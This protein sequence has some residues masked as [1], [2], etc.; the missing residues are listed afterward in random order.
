MLLWG[1]Q[2]WFDV[3]SWGEWDKEVESL[4]E[5]MSRMTKEIMNSGFFDQPP[6]EVKLVF[7]EFPLVSYYT[8]AA[9]RHTEAAETGLRL[10]RE[11]AALCDRKRSL[12]STFV[13]WGQHSLFDS[14][15]AG[16]DGWAMTKMIGQKS[17]FLS[18]FETIVG[19]ESNNSTF[20]AICNRHRILWS[21]ESGFWSQKWTELLALNGRHVD[22]TWMMPAIKAEVKMNDSLSE[23]DEDD[24]EEDLDTV[25]G[26]DAGEET[27]SESSTLREDTVD[28]SSEEEVT[29]RPPTS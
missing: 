10:Y 6:E 1:L 19:M 13:D 25:K 21:G 29:D 7:R 22:M 8:I 2:N 28:T 27:G 14:K 4:D 26:A 16:V 20:T 3:L 11:F 12:L 17:D 15:A 9:R 24:E 5:D 18:Q 23:E